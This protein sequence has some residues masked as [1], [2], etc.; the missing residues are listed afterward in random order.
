[1]ENKTIDIYS[2][3][4]GSGKT[5]TIAMRFIDM[6]VDNPH[7][8]Q[9]ILAV[10]FTNKATAEMK[11]RIVSDL[12]AITYKGDDIKLNKKK[13]ELIERQ[14][15]CRAKTGKPEMAAEEI[16]KRCKTAL[17]L[18][19]NDYGQFSV[20]TIDS[21]VQRVIRAFAFEAGLSSNYGVELDSD[22][23]LSESMD[24]LM[25]DL[26]TDEDLKKWVLEFVHS[27]M[28]EDGKWNVEGRIGGLA[29]MIMTDEGRNFVNE[30][31][32]R[33][34]KDIES[35]K[36]ETA[37]I[38]KQV[39]QDLVS[40]V[41]MAKRDSERFMDSVKGVFKSIIENYDKDDG[42][43]DALV[44]Y[45]L[46]DDT[47]QD[48]LEKIVELSTDPSGMIKKTGK[49]PPSEEEALK[50]AMPICRF[51]ENDGFKRY[52]TARLIRRQIYVI[53]IMADIARKI[54]EWAKEHN[55]MPMSDSNELLR[56]LVGNTDVPFI[57]EKIGS[58]YNN[59]MIDEFQDTSKTQW[60]NFRP[61]VKNSTDLNSKSMLVGD[62]KQAIYRWRN[63]DWHILANMDDQEAE[64]ELSSAVNKVPL[65]TNWRSLA[66][67][68]RFNNAIFSGMKKCVGSYLGGLRKS[69][70]MDGDVKSVYG[71]FYQKIA[72]KNL[73]KGGFAQ[74]RLFRDIEVEKTDS[75][76]KK[77]TKQNKV[78]IKPY[79]LTDMVGVIEMLHREKGYKYGEMCV[80]VRKN[81]EGGRVIDALSSAGIASVSTDSLSLMSSPVICG[82]MSAL[83]YISDP[84]DKSSL[85]SLLAVVDRKGKSI[86]EYW[87]SEE[88]DVDYQMSLSTRLKSLSGMGLLEM[89][90]MIVSEFIRQDLVDTDFIFVE[91]LLDKVRSYITKYHVNLSDF[92]EY[93][94]KA[95]GGLSVVAPENDNAVNVMSIHKSKGLEFK[96]ILMPFADWEIVDSRKS[97]MVWASTDMIPDQGLKTLKRVPVAGSSELSKTYFDGDYIDEQCL[98][99]IDSLNL[100]Y[101]AQT[102]AK[103]VLVMWGKM[104]HE[105][106]SNTP[107][108]YICSLLGFEKEESLSGQK[109]VELTTEWEED[110]VVKTE[111]VTLSKSWNRYRLTEEGSEAEIVTTNDESAA[112]EEGDE[113][114]ESKIVELYRYTLGEI[115][116]SKVMDE[117][118]A[119]ESGSGTHS[120]VI[121]KYKIHKWQS[122]KVNVPVEKED[123]SS[124][125]GTMW[126]DVMA[127]VMTKDDIESAFAN[128]VSDGE[129]TEKESKQMSS[130]ILREIETTKAKEWFDV[131]SDSIY[132]ELSLI[133]KACMKRPDRVVIDSMN[134]VTV[135]DYKF[136]EA[137]KAHQ[138]QVEKYIELLKKAGYTDVH[139]YLWYLDESAMNSSEIKEVE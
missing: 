129:V 8:Y 46:M 88:V 119:G 105:N 127:S 18:M 134:R 41:A 120:E 31:S 62:T 115:P 130:Y 27:T 112:S 5:Y 116:D 125:R 104:S 64:P 14:N 56:A 35:L 97:S 71:N 98:L 51:V 78:D 43:G 109:E 95:G 12:F 121:K 106:K 28:E 48:R 73:D 124:A 53:G 40:A 139:G 111:K 89:V 108:D 113:S 44:K 36:N 52:H 101:V 102:R 11:E 72:S 132:N 74:L 107:V 103:G 82:I 39:K 110:G 25:K 118:E 2:A 24:M 55:V 76:G 69:E 75:K 30:L 58:R 90:E 32:G 83:K 23:V 45:A 117:K 6:L 92:I 136:G 33:D 19:L 79:T 85:I 50:A 38:M 137:K 9:H 60:G 7:N 22:M 20:S 122:V 61:L 87:H 1:M 86:N 67:V 91:A 123:D 99:N 94:D 80:L 70:E 47:A 3:S 63:T 37:V 54:S 15:Q 65:D 84:Y 57:Y 13:H 34:R 17:S 21:F 133:D 93:M 131:A 66:N 77:V 81:K 49:N 59:I 135:V 114:E 128:A 68:I 126:H 96:V 26:G 138:R 4:A 29:K 100:Q 10:T 16:E 42:K